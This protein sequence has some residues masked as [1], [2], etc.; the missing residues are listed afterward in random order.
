MSPRRTNI[1]TEQQT[2]TVHRV[3]VGLIAISISL[4]S[5]ALGTALFV[6]P[7][8]SFLFAPGQSVTPQSV[9]SANAVSL[10]WSAPG[11][12]ATV[13]Q[14]TSYD[15]RYS[16]SPITPV[17][18]SSATPMSSPPLPAPAGATETTAITGLDPSTTYFFALKASDEVGNTSAMSNVATKTTA[19]PPEACIPI[20]TCSEWSAC[21]NGQKT[22]TCSVTN[23]CP[24]GLDAPV[25]T[26][27]C[28]VVVP[29]VPGTTPTTPAVGGGTIISPPAPIVVGSSGPTVS[30]GSTTTTGEPP[31]HVVKNIIV[32]GLGPGASPVVRI[33]DPAKQKPTKEFLAFGSKDKNGVNVA[34]GDV[35]GD[36][37]SYVVAGTGAGTD[38][39]VNLYASAGT[40]LA[41]FNPYPTERKSGVAV[42]TGDVN[43]DGVDEIITIPAKSVSLV[44][45]W[46]YNASTKKFTQV[47]QAVAF[48]TKSRQGFS[49]ST[50]DL[51]QDGRAE[52]VVAPRANGR[53]VVILRLDS[54]N[55]LKLVKRFNP[56]PIAFSSGVTVAVG[57]VFGT[58]RSMVVT[59]PGPSYYA[60]IRVFDNR[61]V[62]QKNFLPQAKSIRNGVSLTT[63]DVNQD[64]RDEVVI[65]N[66]QK[67]DT[68][69]RIFRYN[70]LKQKFEQIQNYLAFPRTVTTGLRL[71]ST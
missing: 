30:T 64:G 26:Q 57:D 45:I 20:Y 67:S 56:Y 25:T 51:N 18:F 58:G 68:T 41:S 69:M 13:G 31:V 11:D 19:D 17:N 55:T 22:R 28:T 4:T 5:L 59:T 1:S 48:D 24:A 3:S 46:K 63:L 50:G 27:Q 32:A 10:T 40:L 42:A 54:D 14:A 61:G 44:R 65:G 60:D 70:G 71:G 12:D 47:T 49:I 23:G 53:S 43:G 16:T 15:I 2:S 37:Q 6:S 33:I 36:H 66:Y 34:A 8:A 62:L 21:V 7:G 38:P 39:K 9:S 29:T 35:V 52:I